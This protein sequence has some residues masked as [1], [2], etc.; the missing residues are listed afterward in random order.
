MRIAIGAILSV[1]GGPARYASELIHALART[2]GEHE[3]T[4]VC[5][6]A[7]G[8][9]SANGAIKDV[10]E[11]PLRHPWEQG[12]W[13]ERAAAALRSKRIDLYH[14]TKGTLP[15]H[16]RLPKVVTVHDLAVFHQPKSFAWL[17][18]VHQRVLVPLSVRMARRIITDSA[19]ARDDLC[20][21]L[22]VPSDRVTIVPLAAREVF[23]PG[24]HAADAAILQRHG[25]KP[26][27]I[28]YA[29]TLQPRKNVELLVQAYQHLGVPGLYLVLAGRCRPGYSPWFL[30]RPP[31]GL[32][33]VGEVEDQSLA[34]LYRNALAFCSPS[35]YEGFGL[36]FLEAM[37]CGCPVVAPEHTS[38]P[39]VLGTAAFYLSRLD[40]PSLVD[41]LSRLC[42]DPEL[43]LELRQRGLERA[44][45]F[46]W[47][48]TAEQTLNVYREA[49][50]G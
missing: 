32:M 16:L 35:G 22:G 38:I 31:H 4:I 43:R 12:F 1:Q 8:L 49:L 44:R 13:E 39:E 47:S 7:A 30:A 36:S 28:L 46:S 18:R 24:P 5:D 2:P 17:Q 11:I 19:H 6:R 33:Y 40:V 3:L 26:P 21:T 15:L 14:G 34:A 9:Q 20:T 50:H 29:G 45:R 10:I 27:Y 23:E 37:A 25:V 48:L 42:R 41:A